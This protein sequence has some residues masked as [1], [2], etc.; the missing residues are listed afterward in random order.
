VAPG[1]RHGRSL[2][3]FFDERGASW[4]FPL[5]YAAL[6]GFYDLAERLITNHP[7]QVNARG[8]R[9][10]APLPAALYKR[11]FRLTNLLHKH[12]AD[13]DCRGNY[14][15]T[16]IH[17]ASID[18][19]VDV[20]RWLLESRRRCKRSGAVSALHTAA[21]GCIPYA[22]RVPTG[23]TRS[24]RKHQLTELALARLRCPWPFS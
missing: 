22:N 18:G 3:Q 9:I 13:V 23:A 20:I 2:V 7:E 5:Y 14:E 19:S 1:A 11:H 24:Q 17:T 21:L 8:G 16:P 6:C 10:H 12:G 15:R 4:W